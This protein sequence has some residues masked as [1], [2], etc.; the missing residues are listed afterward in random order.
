MQIVCVA[1]VL[2]ALEISTQKRNMNCMKNN[3]AKTT[4][5]AVLIRNNKLLLLGK[6]RF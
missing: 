4:F 1:E 3:N 6:C 5:I 2:V